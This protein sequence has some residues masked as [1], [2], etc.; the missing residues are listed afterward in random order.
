VCGELINP[1]EFAPRPRLFIADA[2][3]GSVL[4]VGRIWVEDPAWAPDGQSIAF[5]SWVGPY[6]HS[7]ATERAAR[8]AR[9]NYELFVMSVDAT[10]PRRLTRTAQDEAA[11]AWSPDGTMLAF[12]TQRDTATA[13][14]RLTPMG[15]QSPPIPWTIY[16]MTVDGHKPQ[17][18]TEVGPVDHLSPRWIAEDVVAI[19]AISLQTGKASIVATSLEGRAVS[20]V[21]GP[22]YGPFD[23]HP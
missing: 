12:Q 2:D 8:K 14:F 20:E 4:Q 17:P 9:S 10:A 13:S 1:E 15:P 5:R 7:A 22:Y 16:T 19:A 11:P 6:P 3:G 18:L 23:W 21:E